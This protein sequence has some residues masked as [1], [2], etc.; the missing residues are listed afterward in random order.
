MN[1]TKSQRDDLVQRIENLELNLYDPDRKVLFSI[2]Q[3]RGMNNEIAALRN[4]YNNELPEVELG[5]CPW[6][7]ALLIGRMDIYGL[8]GSFWNATGGSPVTKACQHYVTFLGGLNYH[9]HVPSAKQT[10]FFNDILSGPEVPFI[11]PRLMEL[12]GMKAI[13]NTFPVANGLF[14][15]YT[16]AYFAD[17]PVNPEHGHQVWLR[18]AYYY[19]AANGHRFSDTRNDPWDFDLKRWLE[20]T[21]NVVGWIEPGDDRFQIQTGTTKCPYL[22]IIGRRFG[23]VCR[24]GKMRT[25]PAP[26]GSI[27]DLYD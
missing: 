9:D 25:V 15:A 16:I 6:C 24:Q 5:R 10:G 19:Q 12:K 17:P 27:L 14:T 18:Q 13:L 11:V 21:P 7:E 23:I 3:K 22:G 1:L 8:D 4:Q 26:D 2:E 20:L